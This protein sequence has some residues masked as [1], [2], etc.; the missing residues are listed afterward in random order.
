MTRLEDDDM[1][2]EALFED[3]RANAP[4]M[5][6]G[7]MAQLETQAI[8]AQPAARGSLWNSVLLGLGGMAGLSGIAT[9]AVVGFWIGVAPPEGLPDPTT[10]LEIELGDEPELDGFGWYSDEG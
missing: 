10:L 1:Q 4:A 3:A 2:L 7:F 8:A 6:D 5:R 9:A